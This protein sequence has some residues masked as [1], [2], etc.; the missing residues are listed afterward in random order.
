MVTAY[1]SDRQR[2]AVDTE[3]GRVIACLQSLTTE[4]LADKRYGTPKHSTSSV[5]QLE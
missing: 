4:L 5:A 2:L 1:L 3:D